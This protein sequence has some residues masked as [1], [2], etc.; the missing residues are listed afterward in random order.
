MANFIGMAAF[1][2]VILSSQAGCVTNNTVRDC[3]VSGAKYVSSSSSSSAAATDAEIC[4][5]FVK[6]LNAAM[7]EGGNADMIGEMAIAIEV[8][9]RGSAIARLQTPGADDYPDIAVDVMDRALDQDDLDRLA[10]DVAQM[11]T[12]R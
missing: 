4:A 3:S 6:T 9:Q 8:T 10:R 12:S 11:L 7:A 2:A 1:C 5:R